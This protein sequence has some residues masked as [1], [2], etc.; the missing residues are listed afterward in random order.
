[1]EVKE[2][3]KDIEGFEG[4]Y[5]VS[6][7]GRVKSLNYKGSGKEGILRSNPNPNCIGYGG[8]CLVSLRS[9]TTNTRTYSIHRLVATAFIPNPENKP[10]VNHINHNKQDNRVTNLEWVTQKENVAAYL[11]SQK[12]IE[13]AILRHRI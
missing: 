4:L 6:N 1:M 13:Y 9:K 12:R 7:L 8:Y 11:N 2:V 10:I 3:W 5:Q